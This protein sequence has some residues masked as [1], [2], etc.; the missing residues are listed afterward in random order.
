M[1][2]IKIWYTLEKANGIW[3]IWFNKSNEQETHG[4]YGSARLLSSNNK[5]DC[6]DYCKEKGIKLEGKKRK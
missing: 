1:P 2:K 6:L 4:G 3:T 5:Q